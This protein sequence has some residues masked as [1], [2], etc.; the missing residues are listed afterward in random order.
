VHH[1]TIRK[2]NPTRCNSVSKFIISYLYEAQHVSG[3]T[4]LII[5]SLRLPWQ[6]LIFHTWKV[7]GRVAGG[8]QTEPDNVLYE[9]YSAYYTDIAEVWQIP[10]REINKILSTEMDVLRR[11]ARKSRMERIKK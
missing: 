2:E 6:P 10:A 7:V 1:S 9:L 4:A 3:D 11:S 8:R 5:R